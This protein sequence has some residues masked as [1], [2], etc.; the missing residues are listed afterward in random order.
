MNYEEFLNQI[1]ESIVEYFHKRE[2]E[3]GDNQTEWIAEIHKV[4]KNNGV[5]V[6]GLCI[7]KPG[8]MMSPNIYMKRYYC[9]YE[10]GKSLELIMADIYKRYSSAHKEVCADLLG[11]ADYETVKDRIILQLVNYEMNRQLLA[12]CPHKKFLD[13]AVTFRFLAGKD[14]NGIASSIIRNLEFELW[15]VSIEELYE[16]ALQ[17]TMRLFPYKIE[18]LVNILMRHAMLR[19]KGM[20]QVTEVLEDVKKHE[21]S[22]MGM[23]MYVLTNDSELNGATC[24]LYEGA[25]KEF[26]ESKGGNLIILP[27]SIH[28][29]MIV[30]DNGYD[31]ESLKELVRDAN[32]TAV[33]KMDLL[34]DQVYYYDLEKDE[35]HIYEEEK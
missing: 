30:M 19:Y 2:N 9:D 29:L 35:L 4:V 14:E 22:G 27:S 34:S 26:A 6:D 3:N 33:G 7:R 18:N 17:D 16:T 10:M 5:E 8:D 13:L 21:D 32:M 1:K 24:L 28:E 23:E 12:N 20:S 11:I 15:N 25:L 31:L